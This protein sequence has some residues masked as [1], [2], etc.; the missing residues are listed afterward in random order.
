[1]PLN[2]MIPKITIF[3]DRDEAGIAGS[4]RPYPYFGTMVFQLMS[5]TGTML[6]RW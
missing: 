4:E 3:L 6:L 2:V 5:L 1:M